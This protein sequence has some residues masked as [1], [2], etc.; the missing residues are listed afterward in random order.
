MANYFSLMVDC[1]SLMAFDNEETT[2]ETTV[3]TTPDPNKKTFTQDEVNAIMAKESRKVKDAQTKLMSQLEEAKKASKIG[4]EERASLEKQIEELQK[5]TMTAEE[6]AKQNANKLQKQHKEEIDQRDAEIEKWKNLYTTSTVS[7]ALLKA[8]S[9]NKAK[10]P[11]QIL[12]M[13]RH[14]VKLVAKLDENGKTTDEFEARLDFVDLN[15]DGKEVTMNL[16]V[17]EAVKRMTELPHYGN[18][19]EGTKTGGLGSSNAQGG[20]GKIDIAK[21]A[22]EDPARFRKLRKENPELLTRL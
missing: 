9:Q 1:F 5:Q 10:L 2:T 20:T 3:E 15:D 8:A 11:S 19:F 17:D 13:F 7:N 18:L 16:T 6:R 4:S 12:Q 21:I 22:K 14:D